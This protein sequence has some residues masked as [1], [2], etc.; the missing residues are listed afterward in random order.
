MRTHR[1]RDQMLLACLKVQS[2]NVGLLFWANQSPQPALTG[3]SSKVRFQ[4][5][6]LCAALLSG[7]FRV[8]SN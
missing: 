5:S 7:L 6:P 4:T 8:Q 2:K 1:E 3:R